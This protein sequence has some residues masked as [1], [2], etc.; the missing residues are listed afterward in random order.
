MQTIDLSNPKFVVLL[1]L[2]T[3]VYT[4]N[5]VIV[6]IPTPF[7][8]VVTDVLCGADIYCRAGDHIPLF[9]PRSR[10]FPEP[11][12]SVHLLNY[13]FRQCYVW[14]HAVMMAPCS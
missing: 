14:F 5:V 6:F 10:R 12:D 9:Q 11:S 8:Q 2:V 13:D 4:G 1:L 7:D 3:C